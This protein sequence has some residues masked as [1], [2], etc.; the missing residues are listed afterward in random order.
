MTMSQHYHT[1]IRNDNRMML[2]TV[3][4]IPFID[5]YS[6]WHILLSTVDIAIYCR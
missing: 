4:S 5:I 6:R 2:S 3:D 1:D